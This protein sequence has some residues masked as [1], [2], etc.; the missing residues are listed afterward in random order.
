MQ[1]GSF[2]LLIALFIGVS[3][4][5]QKFFTKDAKV[6]FKSET[7]IEKIDATNNSGT[8]VLDPATNRVECKVLIKNFLFEK[9]LMQEHFNENYMES[10]KFP[11][12][13]FKGNITNPTEVNFAK[14]G[15]Y[16][17]KLSGT[18]N[19]HGVEKP[20]NIIGKVTVKGGIISIHA[21]FAVSA[22][23]YNIPIPSVVSDKIAKSIDVKVDGTLKPMSK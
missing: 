16:T 10:T 6:T 11:N 9:A 12:A 23:D 20:A 14:D 2:V 1:K 8:I 19:M 18:M 21:D 13:T 3:A 22:A 7:P 15:A 4:S 17:A 5:A